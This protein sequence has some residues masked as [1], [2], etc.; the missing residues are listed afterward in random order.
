[1]S[2]TIVKVTITATYVQPDGSSWQWVGGLLRRRQYEK[3][4][5]LS[6]ISL[7]VSAAYAISAAKRLGFWGV[8]FFVA[9]WVTV[10]LWARSR[11]KF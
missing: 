4:L 2:G 7:L 5:A 1:M 11:N 9:I 8:V 3:D 10:F 6:G